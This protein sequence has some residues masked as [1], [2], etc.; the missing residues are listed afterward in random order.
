MTKPG[1]EE[2]SDDRVDEATWLREWLKVHTDV[3]IW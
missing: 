3:K 2:K 1:D